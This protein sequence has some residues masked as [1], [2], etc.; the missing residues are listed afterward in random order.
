M[1]VGSDLRTTM[2][3]GRHSGA[4]ETAM[5]TKKIMPPR[6]WQRLE[7]LLL[8]PLLFIGHLGFMSPAMAQGTLTKTDR[9]HSPRTI[10]P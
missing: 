2:L 9:M 5:G 4:W 1:P 10:M 3:S 8:A 6:P 7:A